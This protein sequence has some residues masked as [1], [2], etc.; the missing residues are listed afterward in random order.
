M[1][2]TIRSMLHDSET[3]Q[4]YWLDAAGDI[5][6]LTDLGK[7]KE[8]AVNLASYFEGKADAFRQSLHL[9]KQ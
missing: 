9:E 2:K 1:A 8:E 6:D 5:Q 7:S 4:Q 3:R